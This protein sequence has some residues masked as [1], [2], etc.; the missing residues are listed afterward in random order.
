MIFHNTP[1]HDV[2][3]IEPSV[4]KDKRGAFVKN[5]QRSLFDQRDLEFDFKESYYTTSHKDVIRGMHFQIPPHDHAKLITV[6]SGSIIDV[7]LDIR[8]SSETYGKNFSLELSADNKKS[9]YIPRGFAH[10]FGVLS[11]VAI[12]Y[13]Q[14]TSE[15]NPDHDKGIH[16][17]SVGF[18]WPISHPILSERDKVL[19]EFS[20]FVTPF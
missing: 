15:Y 6:I 18:S 3:V 13:Y 7:I 8:K 19:P 5:F 2:Y 1:I 11:D 14:V 4:K 17:D 16:F 12:G 9:L 20:N 10:G